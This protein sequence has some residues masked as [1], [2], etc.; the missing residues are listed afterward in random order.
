MDRL[1]LAAARATGGRLIS[2]DDALDGFGVERL[3]D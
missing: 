1:V 2:A 3:S